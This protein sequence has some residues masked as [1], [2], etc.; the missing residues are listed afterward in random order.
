MVSN[1]LLDTPHNT[2]QVK[3][4]VSK[5]FKLQLANVHQNQS[6]LHFLKLRLT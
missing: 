2:Q 3:K 4:L 6:F 5:S 1:M